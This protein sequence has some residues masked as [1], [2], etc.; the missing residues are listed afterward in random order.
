MTK[1]TLRQPADRQPAFSEAFKAF[2]C[3]D[4][5][6]YDESLPR[7]LPAAERAKA[8]R[9]ALSAQFRG[10]RLVIPAGR[11]RT[12]NADNDHP[13]RPDS[14]FVYLT[15]LG[16]DREP[17]A[18]LVLEPVGAA[19][20][21]TLFFHPRVPR[22]NEEFYASARYGEMWVGQ[23]ESLAEMSALCAGLPTAASE[24]LDAAL[25]ERADSTPMRVLR[26]VDPV[27]TATVDA[28]RGRSDRDEK[29]D[30]ELAAGIARLRIVKDDFELDQ[31]RLACAATKAA[32]EAAIVE[33]PR[34]TSRPRGERWIEAT[35]DRTARFE[36]NGVGFHTI[37]AAGDHANTLHW[38]RNDGAVHDGDLVLMDVGVELDTLYTA[39]ITRTLPVN[40]RFSPVQRRVY[41][42]VIEMQDAAQA[43][44]RPGVP[45][46]QVHDAAVAVLARKL[47]DWGVLTVTAEETLGSQGGQHRRWMV[48]G[49]SHHLGLDVHDCSAL[50]RTEYRE[51]VLRPGMVIT[52]EPGLYF[53]STDL[54]V[55][56][57][58]R[59]IGV[60]V[61]DDLVI[62]EDGCRRISA[63]VPRTSDEIEAW[64]APLLERGRSALG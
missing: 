52:N 17:D 36:G 39:D 7:A 53:K 20:E 8:R 45:Y 25:R 47:Q 31:Q 51:G 9:N 38:V 11:A 26:D 41:D 37:A 21:A 24:G 5:A 49:T 42:A 2:I 64:M 55:P 50:P 43:A 57:E 44:A 19:H 22:S 56:E 48:H 40:G 16:T 4:W 10:E 30:G 14:N 29:A 60:R 34:A 6:P 35:F 13:F 23:R 54:L 18:V 15:G 3:T 63:M 32:M 58:L 46:S 59:G 12:R 61:E 28:L 62:T 33:F 27:I 1:D